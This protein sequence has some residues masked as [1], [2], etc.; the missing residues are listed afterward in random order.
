MK[1][2]FENAV[3]AE[4]ANFLT[5]KAMKLRKEDA[6]YKPLKLEY[7]VALLK[8]N[9][10]DEQVTIKADSFSDDELRY[11]I[12]LASHLKTYVIMKDDLCERKISCKSYNKIVLTFNDSA[13]DVILKTDHTDFTAARETALSKITNYTA[14]LK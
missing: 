10:Q 12:A 5:T 2:L 6:A 4:R 9:K 8:A 13:K 3:N 7:E 1:L 14:S 11:G